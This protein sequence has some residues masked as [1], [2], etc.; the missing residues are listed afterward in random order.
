M[1][2]DPHAFKIRMT[3]EKEESD[4]DIF[5]IVTLASEASS[6]LVDKA[7]DE[8]LQKTQKKI[9]EYSEKLKKKFEEIHQLKSMEKS[10]FVSALYFDNFYDEDHGAAGAFPDCSVE[11]VRNDDTGKVDLALNFFLP[12]GFCVEISLS[13]ALQ[14]I[15]FN[16]GDSFDSGAG[17][18]DKQAILSFAQILQ[19]AADDMKARVNA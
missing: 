4:R 14:Q 11:A 16:E 6:K 5:D 17:A 8:S 15:Y 3:Q 10:L 13:K 18:I 19:S 9:D 12:G 2:R 7:L 1:F